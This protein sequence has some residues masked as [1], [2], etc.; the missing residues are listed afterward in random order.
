MKEILYS[1]L[2]YIL[3]LI[4]S[5]VFLF[6]I[7]F[8]INV[9][10]FFKIKD[11]V[12]GIDYILKLILLPTFFNSIYNSMILSIFVFVIFVINYQ[13]RFKFLSSLIPLIITSGIVFCIIFFYK[14][15][16]SDLFY[17]NINDARLY[18]SEKSFFDYKEEIP[19][20][21]DKLEFETKILLKIKDKSDEKVLADNYYYD[22]KKSKYFLKKD[23]AEL[24]YKKIQDI[25]YNS[26][27]F[28]K[29]K[30][31]FEKVGKNNV[32]NIIYF[33]NDKTY[34][35]KQMNVSFIEDRIFLTNPET[36][37]RFEFIKNNITEK[38][39]INILIDKWIF[40][41]FVSITHKFLE[42]KNIVQNVIFWAAVAFFIISFCMVIFYK[43]YPYISM[44][45]KLFFLLLF[46]IFFVLI[47]DIYDKNFSLVVPA[48]LLV[49]KNYFFSAVLII[50]AGILQLVRLLF[51]KSNTWEK[52]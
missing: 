40:G 46:Y 12:L 23:F 20:T 38:D 25:F 29:Q 24:S 28:E 18:L 49:I 22:Y 31:Y 9:L 2:K 15:G 35:Y 6:G 34:F 13:A 4:L 33:K 37:E 27:Y 17:E 51:F 10:P 41:N 48:N 1:L 47:F 3:I 14:P 52:E 30:L 16:Y 42:Y 36:N 26:G 5:F 45:V 43:S 7:F 11:G 39:S 8:V 21:F 44:I 19:V 32:E 50:F